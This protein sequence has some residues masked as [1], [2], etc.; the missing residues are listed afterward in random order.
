MIIFEWILKFTPTIIPIIFYDT[1][2]GRR[3]VE[4]KNI[5]DKSYYGNMGTH[6][7]HEREYTREIILQY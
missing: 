4:D 7:V 1:V 3:I 6:T 5:L 2:W